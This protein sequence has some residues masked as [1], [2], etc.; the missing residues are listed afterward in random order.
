MT[1]Y[2]KNV[3]DICHTSFDVLTAAA[4]LLRLRKERAVSLAAIREL[5]ALQVECAWAAVTA[6][7]LITAAETG[8]S[9]QELALELKKLTRQM[10][11]IGFALE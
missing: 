10:S 4:T 3:I 9:H 8:V 11:K 2:E 5:E 7:E 6:G 1:D